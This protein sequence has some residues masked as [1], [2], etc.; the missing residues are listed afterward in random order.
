MQNKTKSNNLLVFLENFNN[1]YESLISGI[2]KSKTN[3]SPDVNVKEAENLRNRD[4]VCSPKKF[5]RESYRG[6][7]QDEMSLLVMNQTKEVN[8][9]NSSLKDLYDDSNVYTLSTIKSSKVYFDQE[10]IVIY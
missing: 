7:Y 9:A 4:L 10:G 6:T 1:N 2:K 5:P 8:L 3:S